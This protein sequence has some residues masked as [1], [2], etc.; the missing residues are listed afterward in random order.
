[1]YGFQNVHSLYFKI[2]LV[3]WYFW[4]AEHEIGQHNSI[5]L[6]P[7]ESVPRPISPW[8]NQWW[9]AFLKSGGK[10]YIFGKGTSSSTRCYLLFSGHEGQARDIGFF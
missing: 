1:M 5:M 7:R 6:R 10:L 2:Y 3:N 4:P 8:A 9:D